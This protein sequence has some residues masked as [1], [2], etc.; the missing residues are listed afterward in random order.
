MFTIGDYITLSNTAIVTM[1]ELIAEFGTTI[2][3]VMFRMK[4][5]IITFVFVAWF[6]VNTVVQ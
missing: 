1:M 4:E 2:G 3:S 6:R 5:L